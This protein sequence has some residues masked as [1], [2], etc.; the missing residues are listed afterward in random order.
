MAGY[1]D[2]VPRVV[3]VLLI[4]VMRAVVGVVCFA[5]GIVS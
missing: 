1:V 5:H 2:G 4:V 3:S